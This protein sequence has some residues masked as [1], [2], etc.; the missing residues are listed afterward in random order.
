[1]RQESE[2]G[3]ETGSEKVRQESETGREKK[4]KGVEP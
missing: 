1:V 2:I 4:P 3:S